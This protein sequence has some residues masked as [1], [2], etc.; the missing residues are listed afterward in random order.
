M[1]LVVCNFTPVRRE[2][3]RVGVP[4]G[5]G[6]RELANS[7]ASEFGGSGAGNGGWVDAEPVGA[8]E[9]PYS[10]R[11]TLPPLGVLLLAPGGTA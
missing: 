4:V 2:G 8:H 7:D 10:L 5:G 3:Y 9:R 1:V 6:W 11:L